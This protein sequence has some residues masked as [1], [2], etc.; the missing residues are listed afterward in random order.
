MKSVRRMAAACALLCA[1]VIT[2]YG[3]S[4]SSGHQAGAPIFKP[5]PWGELE[6]T[7]I[8]LEAPEDLLALYPLPS[9]TPHWVFPGATRDTLEDLFRRAGLSAEV[10]DRLLAPRQ[11]GAANGTLYL[12]PSV[13]EIEAMT[14]EAR[15]VIYRELARWSENTYYN[16]PVL[17]LSGSVEQWLRN[18]GVRPEIQRRIAG[19]TYRQGDTLAFSD[20]EALLSYAESD[21]EARFLFKVLTRVRTMIVHVKLGSPENLSDL[22]RYWSAGYRR[23]DIM[24]ILESITERATVP[25]IDLIHLLPPLPRR[26]LYRYPAP[27]LATHGR[28]PD[29]HWTSL[30]FFNYTP[31]NLFLDER[32][33]AS[34]VLANYSAV[35]PPHRYGDILF[36]LDNNT[37]LTIHSCVYL[38]DNLV[39]TKNGESLLTPWILM[40][41]DDIKSVYLKGRNA[42]IVGYRRNPPPAG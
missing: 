32:L 25:S 40:T 3:S 19:L 29:C 8:Y 33:R 20:V 27:E 13:A 2:G 42:E 7:Y 28:M 39:F 34:R 26:L 5:G 14:P 22:V 24:P 35:K 41:L 15:A 17:I 36:V 1:T 37:G 4:R 30:N 6:Y 16:D 12:N 10:R 38:A 23:T 21:A 9:T 11:I 18:T 31:E